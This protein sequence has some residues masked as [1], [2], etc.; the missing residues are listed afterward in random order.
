MELDS[1][2]LFMVLQY[3]S[4]DEI[5]RIRRVSTLYSR[6]ASS[7]ALWEPILKAFAG[8]DNTH[9]ENCFIE[10]KNIIRKLPYVISE[11]TYTKI[12]NQASIML[13]NEKHNKMSYT[14]LRIEDSEDINKDTF[15]MAAIL[16]VLNEN[17]HIPR[18]NDTIL[19]TNTTIQGA[20]K[21]IGIPL[22]ELCYCVCN[23]M[24]EE[25]SE[26]R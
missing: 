23:G 10:F 22:Y 9:C 5:Y 3:L 14:Y 15:K 4:L 6:V 24:L 18:L 2:C 8:I 13:P 25:R 1:D 20:Y 11:N 12:A 19:F 16:S 21:R 26:E 17:G 7:N